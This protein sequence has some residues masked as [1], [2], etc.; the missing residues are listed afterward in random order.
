MRLR[1]FGRRGLT[2]ALLGA[3]LCP[4]ASAAPRIGI[5]P[6]QPGDRVTYVFTSTTYTPGREDHE[7]G[8]F[9]LLRGKNGTFEI[10]FTPEGA[11]NQ[12]FPGVLQRDGTIDLDITS[13]AKQPPFILQRF[14]QIAILAGSAPATFK[15]GDTWKTILTVP[16]PRG[17]SVDVPILVTVSA[18]SDAGFDLEGHGDARTRLI[19]GNPGSPGA[20]GDT[21]DTG[22]PMELN[23]HSAGHFVAGKL[24]R[25]EGTLH[26]TVQAS[27]VIDITSKWALSVQKPAG[28]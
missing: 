15:S 3:L 4:V 26:S 8:S 19:T 16:L 18:A 24:E 27:S 20:A 9:G 5:V 13:D 21:S 14:N 6:L 11:V 2:G 1:G 17:A 25:A 22:L 10:D 7:D 12:T 23:L 28:S